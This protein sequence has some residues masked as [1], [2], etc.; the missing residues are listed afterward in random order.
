MEVPRTRHWA[1]RPRWLT[2]RSSNQISPPSDGSRSPSRL[3]SVDLPEPEAPIT[4]TNS[5]PLTS[6]STAPSTGTGWPDGSRYTLLSP[7]A[8]T[9]IP[10][11]PALASP[12]PN[13][14][15]P[16][17]ARTSGA[18][19]NGLGRRQPDDAQGGVGSRQRAQDQRETE[20]EQQEPGGE[21]EELLPL[22]QNARVDEPADQQGQPHARRAARQTHAERLAQHFA[23]QLGVGGTE[24]ALDAEVA[25]PLEHRRRHG[26]GEGQPADDQAQRANAEKQRGEE[27]GGVAQQPAHRARDRHVDPADAMLD[28]AGE[29][30]GVL[31]RRPAD[32]GAGIEVGAREPARAAADGLHEQRIAPQ[33]EL[34]R[35]L[36][37]HHGEAVWRRLF[38]DRHA[39]HRELE[40]ADR[41]PI[42]RP[43]APRGGEVGAHHR[44]PAVT[45]REG[46][47]GPDGQRAIVTIRRRR[48]EVEPE[49][50][51]LRHRQE[52]GRRGIER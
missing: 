49:H 23:E 45:E 28:A 40:P 16:V 24:R 2:R 13:R 31:A 47:A 43:E 22:A 15:G 37:G 46:A 19:A 7:V 3:S 25:D 12:G 21:Q 30:V 18:P 41:Q 6:S 27:G 17:S 26:I 42:A 38:F 39:D 4:A 34:A 48:R 10:S 52:L 8:R 50:E 9:I 11:V 1:R 44:D 35:V 29:R 5:P 32:G 51:L 33:P 36:D 20:R 14:D